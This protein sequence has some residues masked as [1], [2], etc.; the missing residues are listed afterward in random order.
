MVGSRWTGLHRKSGCLSK[1]YGIG[2]KVQFASAQIFPNFREGQTV[3]YLYNSWN[4]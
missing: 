2:K 1:K 3:F 4:F